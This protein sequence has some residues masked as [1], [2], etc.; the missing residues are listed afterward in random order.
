MKRVV[1]MLTLTLDVEA[2]AALEVSHH[3]SVLSLSAVVHVLDNQF[4]GLLLREH[5]VVIVWLQLH[6]IEHPFHGDVVLGDA[7]LKY[8]S[9]TQQ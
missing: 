3:S 6:L 8:C 7:Q 4:V 5:P 1:L 9:C 2:S